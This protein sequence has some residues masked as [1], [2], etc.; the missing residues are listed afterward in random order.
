MKSLKPYQKWLLSEQL[1]VSERYEELGAEGLL[2]LLTNRTKKAIQEMARKLEVASNRPNWT[3][4]HKQ[5]L[6][7]NYE[8]LGIKRCAQYLKRSPLSVKLQWYRMK[9]TGENEDELDNL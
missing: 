7:E 9:Q 3:S 4:K 5:Y 8:K 6:Q 1:I 2:P